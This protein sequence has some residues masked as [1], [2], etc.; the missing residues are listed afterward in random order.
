MIFKRLNLSFSAQQNGNNNAESKRNE[1]TPELMLY[2]SA[3]ESKLVVME[4]KS[5][6]IHIPSIQRDPTWFWLWLLELKMGTLLVEWITVAK[7]FVL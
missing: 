4:I 2:R 7:G 3:A 1:K 5:Y 6:S